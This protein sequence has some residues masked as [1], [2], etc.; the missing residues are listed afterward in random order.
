VDGDSVVIDA[1]GQS[2]GRLPA[3]VAILVNNLAA[4]LALPKR[5]MIVRAGKRILHV[6]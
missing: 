4:I 1:R 3:I 2:V 5:T 6:L